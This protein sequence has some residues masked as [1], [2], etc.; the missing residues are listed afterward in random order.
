M[1]SEDL[2]QAPRPEL[3]NLFLLP[4]LDTSFARQMVAAVQAAETA[5]DDVAVTNDIRRINLRD[6]KSLIAELDAVD[7]KYYDGVA[8]FAL[9]VPGVRQAIDRVVAK[10][11]KVVPIVTDI[12]TSKR[13][14]FVGTDNT[15]AGRV[16]GTLMGRFAGERRGTIAVLVGSLQMRD[17]LDRYFGFEQIIRAEFPD[18]RILPVEEGDSLRERNLAITE[19]LLAEH[20]DLV[21]L[22]SAAAGNSGILDALEQRAESAGLV[23]ILHELSGPCSG[24]A[25]QRCRRCRDR[26]GHRPHRPKRRACSKSALS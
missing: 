21:G 5:V 10:G 20:D 9:D 18:L 16:A 2:L 17:H 3:R 4:K 24:R 14:F 13:H 8:L 19:R 6:G 7:P 26:T 12:P 25:Y 15:S 23:V 22:Y 1:L 11:V